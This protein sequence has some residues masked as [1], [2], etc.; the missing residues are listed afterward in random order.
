M[1]KTRSNLVASLASL[2]GLIGA[3]GVLGASALLGGCA[4]STTPGP[5]VGPGTLKPPAYSEVA[6][7]F[8]QRVELLHRLWARTT[9]IVEQ[10]D[11]D[12]PGGRLRDQAEG[13]LQ[14]ERPDRFALSVMKLGDIYF[15]LGSNEER[16]WWIDRLSEER[17]AL[18]GRH[19]RATPERAE[20]LGIPIHPLDMMD[21][22]GVTPLPDD[23]GTPIGPT[24]E[25][26]VA[27]A[28]SG[29]LSVEVPARWGSRRVVFDPATYEPVRVEMLDSTGAVSLV[30][31]LSRYNP[32]R[33]RGR[34][35]PG[36]GVARR[37]VIEAPRHG[38]TLTIDLYEPENKEISEQA[39]S[40]EALV[41]AYVRGGEVIDLDAIADEAGAGL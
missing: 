21:L 11:P 28:E 9:L 19:A 37:A 33:V 32:I 30:S 25:G 31:E 41:R 1:S 39:F 13:H 15:Y 7:A 34:G 26:R 8:N 4:R 14:L 38:A 29:L 20:L 17:I 2:A 5:E 16:Y 22:L 35:L 12:D 40:F 6:S 3:V 36:P 23:S 10:P 24:T 18:F 27:W